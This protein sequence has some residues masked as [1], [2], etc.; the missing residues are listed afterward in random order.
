MLLPCSTDDKSSAAECSLQTFAISLTAWTYLKCLSHGYLSCEFLRHAV[1][2]VDHASIR[3]DFCTSMFFRKREKSLCTSVNNNNN[4]KTQDITV[5]SC[6]LWSLNSFKIFILYLENIPC[7]FYHRESKP[8]STN[9]GFSLTKAEKDTW[10][11]CGLGRA[12]TPQRAGGSRHTNGRATAAW[13]ETKIQ[14]REEK[15][16]I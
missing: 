1:L 10:F 7:S 13:S 6:R 9:T 3:T 5:V 15:G 12:P 14:G 4:I 11:S 2:K 8:T 16:V